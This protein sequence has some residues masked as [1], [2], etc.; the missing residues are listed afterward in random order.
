M[1]QEHN[2]SEVAALRKAIE[3][4]YL[5]ARRGLYG[6]AQYA[7]HDFIQAR[8]QGVGR[9]YEELS[10][11]LGEERAIDL[12]IEVNDELIPPQTGQN[13]P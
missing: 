10:R 13:Q 11:L 9:H 7:Q 6:L 8:M 2:C 4:E 12:V 5:A 3:D 1:S